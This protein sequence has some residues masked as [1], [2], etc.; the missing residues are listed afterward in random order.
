LAEVNT[1]A[2]ERDPFISSDGLTLYFASDR[3][4]SLGAQDI[5]VTIRPNLQTQF[6][7]PPNLAELNGAFS[8][9]NPTISDSGLL[10]WDSTRAGGPG[11][12]FGYDI[13]QA[14]LQ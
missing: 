5:W 6:E 14:Q 11:G 2:T 12:T 10:V 7:P 8:Q 1:A 4:G 3:P 13:W 9:G